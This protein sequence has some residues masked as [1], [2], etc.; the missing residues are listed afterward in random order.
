M[1]EPSSRASSKRLVKCS[2]QH[3]LMAHSHSHSHS[4]SHT[5]SLSVSSSGDRRACYYYYCCSVFELV[6]LALASYLVSNTVEITS[7]VHGVQRQITREA[8]EHD[9]ALAVE[10]PRSESDAF[11][12]R[13]VSVCQAIVLEAV[14]RQL[15]RNSKTDLL[16]T[17]GASVACTQRR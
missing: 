5:L 13:N 15:R 12:V 1:Q 8:I 10:K 16:V 2:T 6:A 9:S 4:H 7:V 17:S 11:M 3:V 14:E